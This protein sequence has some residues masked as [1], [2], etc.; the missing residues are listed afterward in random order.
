MTSIPPFELLQ[1]PTLANIAEAKMHAR[2]ESRSQVRSVHQVGHDTRGCR[3][4]HR[5]SRRQSLVDLSG[6]RLNNLDLSGLD[7]SKTKLE[8]AYINGANFTG[9]NLNRREA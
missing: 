4:G 2:F 1:H 8:G 7:L 3:S 6:K 5:V 9:S